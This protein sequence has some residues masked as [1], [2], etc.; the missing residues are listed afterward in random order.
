MLPLATVSLQ[1]ACGFSG[2][3]IDLSPNR[4]MEGPAQV[5]AV[6]QIAESTSPTLPPVAIEEMSA[7]ESPHLGQTD[8]TPPVWIDVSRDQAGPLDD[9]LVVSA[10][11]EEPEVESASQLVESMERP[12]AVASSPIPET[13]VAN[14]RSKPSPL[15]AAALFACVG[16]L[17]ICLG[18]L[19][20]L[21]QSLLFRRCLR[22]AQLLNA[23]PAR[24]ELDR[25]LRHAGVRRRV[26]LL[27]S[28]RFSEPVVFGL[29]RWKMILPCGL[30]SRLPPDELRAL[31]A[32]ELA[33][34]VRGNT[35][36][37]TVGRVLCS[38][39]CFQPLNLLARRRWQQAAEILCDEWSLEQGA[40]PLALARCL[41]RIAESRMTGRLAA[42]ALAAGGAAS[43]LSQR[44]E[45]LI[46]EEAPEAGSGRNCRRGMI[47]TGM[48]AAA[49][50]V[51][52]GPRTMLQAEPVAPTAD[53]LIPEPQAGAL[54]EELRLLDGELTQLRQELQRLQQLAGRSDNTDV[55]ALSRELSVRIGLLTERHQSLA[56]A[57][58][59][60]ETD[61]VA[62]LESL[63]ATDLRRHRSSN[64]IQ[65]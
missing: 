31:L 43:T 30:E 23:G 21:I 33:H 4:P 64:G 55:G 50:M 26:T 1:W 38:C 40:S 35:I 37:L 63:Q 9:E 42:G 17:L 12:V 18:A 8:V 51:T 44:V 29:F 39:G 5:A 7:D 20:L 36:W 54:D 61:N 53:E 16:L 59:E 58:T 22:S 57:V 25:L 11:E 3:S 45:R 13:P 28:D 52:V 10:T 14:A 6:A 65:D 32:H 27:E 15:S 60:T 49:L 56:D 47:V 34:L 46:R 24:V 48:L 62:A 2:L 19:R 41:T